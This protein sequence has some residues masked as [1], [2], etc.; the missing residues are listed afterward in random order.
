[1]P[2][3][4]SGIIIR[5]VG[6]AYVNVSDEPRPWS[7]RKMSKIKSTLK[8]AKIGKKSAFSSSSSISERIDLAGKFGDFSVPFYFGSDPSAKWETST[9]TTVTCPRSQRSTLQRDHQGPGVVIKKSSLR[10][11]EEANR[12]FKSHEKYF[13]HKAY[14]FGHRYSSSREMMWTGKHSFPF[15]YTLPSKLPASF[16][17]RFGYVR[18]FCEASLERLNLPTIQRSTFFSVNT[19]TDLNTDSKADSGVSKGKKTNSW[20]FCCA[21]GTV[22]VSTKVKRRG[23]VPGET[24]PIQAHILNVSNKMISRVSAKVI[25]IATYYSSKAFRNHADESIVSEKVRGSVPPGESS[26]WEGEG[27]RV[28]PVPPTSTMI[29]CKLITIDYRLDFVLDITGV[30]ESQVVRMPLKIGSVPL[31]KTFKSFLDSSVEEDSPFKTALPLN[32]QSKY[33][34][35][36]GPYSIKCVKGDRNVNRYYFRQIPRMNSTVRGITFRMPNAPIQPVLTDEL[37]V[38]APRYLTYRE[39]TKRDSD[40]KAAGKQVATINGGVPSENGLQRHLVI[41]V[42]PPGHSRRITP[43]SATR[44][45]SDTASDSGS[46]WNSPISLKSKKS[47]PAM[48]LDFITFISDAKTLTSDRF[49]QTTGQDTCQEEKKDEE[50]PNLAKY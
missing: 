11:Q 32:I 3:E 21:S 10:R 33:S 26:T 35:L 30:K 4:C 40:S 27:P 28:P 42:T 15:S 19:I 39:I 50:G 5:I 49:K 17:G 37:A 46:I 8:S 2:E 36:P 29:D 20:C 47:L 41:R 16:H 48:N 6:E 13:E 7:G 18:Y 1:M 24:I 22:I 31:E 43:C 9:T 23:F 14:L 34:N 44:L 25:Q 12:R 45:I 38:Y